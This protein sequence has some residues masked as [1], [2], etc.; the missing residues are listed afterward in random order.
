MLEQKYFCSK[1]ELVLLFLKL[2]VTGFGGPIAHIAMM[3]E[4]VVIKRSWL[5]EEEFMD[6]VSATNLIPGPN[7]TELAIHVGHKVLGRWGLLIAGG[8]FI[9]PAFLIV[10]TIS[11]AYSQFGKLPQLASIMLG[12]RPV[13]ISIILLALIGF[14]KAALARSPQYLSFLF[15]I[16]LM[17]FGVNELLILVLSGL[18]AI[19]H[20]RLLSL[21]PILMLGPSLIKTMTSQ[22]IFFYFLKIGSVLFGSGYV[23]FAFLKKELVD[24]KMWLT[25]QQ[26]MDAITVG[27]IT[28]GPVFTSAT[29]IGFLLNGY[30]GALLAT[31]G[32]F[33]PAFIFVAISIPLVRKLRANKKFSEIIDGINAASFALLMAVTYELGVKSLFSFSTI[34]IFVLSFLI[35]KYSRL[36]SSWM[37]FI[38]GIVGYYFL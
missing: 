28:P 26:L 9:L 3:R 10:L 27:Q 33:L 15:S 17:W 19:R 32:I 38:G 35:L 13:I 5:S 8:C 34:L 23:L 30:E 6:L 25:T 4:E 21:S 20:F 31:V 14:R 29:F 22:S 12:V 24:E 36:N 2:G 1:K 18:I 16:V 11:V 7:S 37:V